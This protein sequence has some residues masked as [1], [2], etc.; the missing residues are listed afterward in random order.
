MS[1]R[2]IALHRMVLSTDFKVICHMTQGFTVGVKGLIASLHVVQLLEMILIFSG[3]T[4]G[5]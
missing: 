2:N 1:F 4:Q 3:T 5:Y